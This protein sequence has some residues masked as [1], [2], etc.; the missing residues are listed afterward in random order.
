MTLGIARLKSL[1]YAREERIKRL[2]KCEN[3]LSVAEYP[4][5]EKPL[6]I[7]DALHTWHGC[8]ASSEE[9]IDPSFRPRRQQL[10]YT[11]VIDHT[12]DFDE[13]V[14][15]GGCETVITMDLVQHNVESCQIEAVHGDVVPTVAMGVI[16][17]VGAHEGA[18]EGGDRMLDEEG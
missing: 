5:D 18:A 2:E 8:V 16:L 13:K 15:R 7:L 6:R 1:I 12:R 4:C 17:V 11:V 3:L 10:T 14:K 9:D